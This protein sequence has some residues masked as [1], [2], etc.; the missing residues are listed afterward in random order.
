MNRNFYERKS[1]CR[2]ESRKLEMKVV[3]LFSAI[4]GKLAG[5]TTLIFVFQIRFVASHSGGI[6]FHLRKAFS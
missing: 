6:F 5:L 3:R 2:A 1:K 4:F